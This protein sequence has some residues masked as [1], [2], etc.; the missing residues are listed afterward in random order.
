MKSALVLLILISCTSAKHYRNMDGTYSSS[1][2]DYSYELSLKTFD[3][4]FHLIERRLGTKFQCYGNWKIISKDS[5]RLTCNSDTSM[6]NQ[7][8]VGYMPARE[9][10]VK[11]LKYNQLQLLTVKLDKK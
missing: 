1:G 8:S 7:M 10:H 5:I 6:I 3:S 4:T 2:K 11:I 9:H